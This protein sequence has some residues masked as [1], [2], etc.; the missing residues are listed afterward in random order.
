MGPAGNAGATEGPAIREGVRDRSRRRGLRE[1]EL[2]CCSS[3]GQRHRALEDVFAILARALPCPTPTRCVR[4]RHLVPHLVGLPDPG[5]PC[6]CRRSSSRLSASIMHIPEWLKERYPWYMQTFNI[7]NYTIG[8]LATWGAAHLVLRRPGL[9]PNDG[10]ALGARRR[11]PPAPSR[12]RRTTSCSRRWSRLAS[13]VRSAARAS[14]PSRAS[15]PTSSSRRSGSRS[16]PSGTQPVADPV[17]GRAAAPDPSLALDP[18]ASGR[19]ADRREDGALQ[20]PPLRRRHAGGARACRAVPAAD[21]ADHGRP[22]P[23]ARHQQHLRPSRGRRRAPRH[24]RGLPTGASPLRRAR[25]VRR[26][27]VL[28]PAARDAARAGVRDRGADSAHG[29]RAFLRGR[30]LERADPRD[31]LDGR[32]ELPPGRSRAERAR[33]PGRPCGVPRKAA[34]PKPRPRRLR[35][36][37]PRPARAAR[38]AARNGA[39]R[40]S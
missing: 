13:P 6:S 26:R 3:A 19:S 1:A 35:R 20:R 14:S 36:A 32:R 33:P 30:D 15:R 11:S 18:T 29:R 22:R 4:A 5:A 24:L 38:P 34:G 28:D 37:D 23:V 39:A 27:G 31:D 21:V 16:P 12:S 25:P 9:I 2:S 40:G 8:N 17:R 7:C 10:P